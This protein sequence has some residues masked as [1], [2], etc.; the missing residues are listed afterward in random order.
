MCTRF[1]LSL[2]P[3]PARGDLAAADP[4]NVPPPPEILPLPQLRPGRIWSPLTRTAR[5]PP[6]ETVAPITSAK[7]TS[8]LRPGLNG[9]PAP[10][11]VWVWPPPETA[12]FT[13]AQASMASQVISKR[14]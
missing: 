10:A 13:S 12:A 1:R 11:M 4:H 3:A 7:W 8:V 6:P 2:S 9:S 5:P 14:R